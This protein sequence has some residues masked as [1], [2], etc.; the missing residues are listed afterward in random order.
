M[1]KTKFQ[2]TIT[3]FNFIILIYLLVELGVLDWIRQFILLLL[4][5][6]VYIYNHALEICK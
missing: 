2:I 5:T 4:F 6:F 3:T 1:K